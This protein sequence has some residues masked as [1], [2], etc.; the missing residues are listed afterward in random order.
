MV[1]SSRDSRFSECA[2]VLYLE[3]GSLSDEDK[4]CYLRRFKLWKNY[5]Y[6]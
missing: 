6:Y 4:H 2:V 3:L 1:Y 5:I